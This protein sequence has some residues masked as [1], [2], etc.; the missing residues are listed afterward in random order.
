MICMSCNKKIPDDALFCQWCGKKQEKTQVGYHRRGNGLGS[1][2]RLPSGKWKAECTLGYY[3]V[4]GKKRRKTKK[5]EGFKTKKEAVQYLEAFLSREIKNDSVKLSELWE[6]VE[7]ELDKLSVSKQSAYKIAW[8]KLCPLLG[9]RNIT[10]ITVRELQQAVDASGATYYPRKDA[11]VLLVKLYNYALINDQIEKNR[12]E[13]VQLPP[14][15]QSDH[16]VFTSEDK[17]A[18]WA[19]YDATH[20][21]ITAGI[22]VMLYTGIRPAELLGIEVDNVHLDAHYM[23]GGVKT[24][25]GKRRK[26]I[27][28]D[29]LVPVVSQLLETS[30][31]GKLCYF[32]KTDFYDYWK[33][34][35]EALGLRESLS[36][37]CCRHTYITDLTALNVSPAMLKE[38]AGHEDYETT[39]NYTHLSVDDRL[40]EVNRLK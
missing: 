38:L 17:A 37:Y 14:I 40:R 3:V 12:A 31:R 8:K 13:Y 26:I 34:K 29:I 28:P 36:P 16:D 1:V 19:D 18:L 35:R 32:Y 7:P 4:D 24:E 15:P 25:K 9:W 5:K 21:R 33:A 22:L 23:T 10:D 11:K 27:I 20:A 39:L 6:G 30:S 2:Y